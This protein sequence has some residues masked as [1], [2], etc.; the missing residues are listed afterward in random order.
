MPWTN[1]RGSIN[2][3]DLKINLRNT[4]IQNISTN[5]DVTYTK[6]KVGSQGF[7]VYILANNI[8]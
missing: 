5:P 3:L 2:K 4:M 6:L 8:K 7:N 1:N